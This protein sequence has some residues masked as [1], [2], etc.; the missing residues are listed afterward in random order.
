[1]L[2]HAWMYYSVA[3]NGTTAVRHVLLVYSLK[4]KIFGWVF[5]VVQVQNNCHVPVTCGMQ[6]DR[7]YYG[8][9]TK[10]FSSTLILE[11]I[12]DYSAEENEMGQEYILAHTSAGPHSY[13]F[14]RCYRLGYWCLSS[15]SQCL[16]LHPVGYPEMGL[17]FLSLLYDD[18]LGT[19][20]WIQV[21]LSYVRLCLA[22]MG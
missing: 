17:F 3:R 14:S 16:S 20:T 11:W 18:F 19:S 22:I 21:G 9:S 12:Q 10:I 2:P 4:T 1:M 15:S 5:F 13:F 8:Y 6:L 7:K